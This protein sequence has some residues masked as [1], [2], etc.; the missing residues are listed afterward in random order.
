MVQRDNTS[1]PVFTIAS[2]NR[3]KLVLKDVL[4]KNY[5][6][7]AIIDTGSGI[8]VFS[9][10]LC[11][12]L[13]FPIKKWHGPNVFLAGEKQASVEGAV[14]A[15]VLI[16]GR[17]VFGCALVFEINDY[18]LLL[19]NDA[20]RQLKMIKI[21]YAEGRAVFKLGNIDMEDQ[22]PEKTNFNFL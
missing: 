18:D 17:T 6:V 19:G 13:Q 16:N 2:S 5:S 8:T 1:S 9:P 20:L 21:N 14:D 22:A 7:E 3:S 4:C 11:R 12:Y 15:K 10:Q